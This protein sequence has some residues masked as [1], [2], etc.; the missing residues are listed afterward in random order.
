MTNTYTYHVPTLVVGDIIM[1]LRRNACK[2]KTGI[3]VNGFTDVTFSGDVVDKR[4][5]LVTWKQSLKNLKEEE[6]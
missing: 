5:V 4:A 6:A 3:D 2:V 1:T